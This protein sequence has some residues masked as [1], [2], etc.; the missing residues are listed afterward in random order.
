MLLTTFFHGISNLM[1]AQQTSNAYQVAISLFVV[2][3][4]LCD[5]RLADI[6]P[7]VID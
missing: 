4:L 3:I 6:R 1:H 5:E 2:S 7:T